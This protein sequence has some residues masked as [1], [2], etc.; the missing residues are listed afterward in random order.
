MIYIKTMS[1]VRQTKYSKATLE[2]FGQKRHATNAEVLD[3]LHSRLGYVSPTTVHR[4]T[5]RLKQQGKLAEAPQDAAGAMR[6]DA[7][8][9]PHDHFM[10]QLCG[11]I[12]DIDIADIVSPLIS[13][14]VGGC[15]ITGRL[16]VQGSCVSCMEQKGDN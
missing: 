1:D 4:I 2:F 5:A 11:G 15:Q 8:L 6:Y 14:Q 7:N 13:E 9:T 10:C 3:Y 12:R 16:V